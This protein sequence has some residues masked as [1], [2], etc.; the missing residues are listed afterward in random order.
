MTHSHTHIHGHETKNLRTAFFLNLGFTILEVVGGVMTNSV[1][2]LSDA[3]HDAGDCL[4]I[5][6]SWYLQKLSRKGSNEKFTYGYK[7]F[8][9]LGALI[10]GTV[11]VIGMIVII[12]KA[13]PRLS[14][15]QPVNTK[16]MLALAVFGIVVNGIAA[17]TAS[18]GSSINEGVVSW[19]LIEDVLGWIA[20]LVGSLVMTFWNLPIVDPL[21]S[22][23][24][25]LFILRNVAVQ[26]HRALK[27]FL[28]RAP[29]GFDFEK[30]ERD[31]TSM[32]QVRST[33]H[34]HSWSLDG[35]AHVLTAHVVLDKEVEREQLLQVKKSIKDLLC[36]QHFEH[37]TLELELEDEE[38][39]LPDD[40]DDGE[41]EDSEKEKEGES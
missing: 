34:I 1:A 19:H 12:A 30:L 8:S 26:L 28:Q 4:S 15:P 6:V 23:G 17:Y 16:G 31:I 25:A 33:H 7:R 21:M 18:R 22:I 29:E 13:V 36:D 9:V 37:V 41:Q 3:L 27:V 10:T 24:I 32:P 20:V 38:C 2:I 11:L 40:D 5:G 14:E 35:E 39:S